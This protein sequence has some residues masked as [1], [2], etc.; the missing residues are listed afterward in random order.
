ML[1]CVIERQ[2]PQNWLYLPGNKP[3]H[4]QSSCWDVGHCCLGWVAQTQNVIWC[5]ICDSPKISAVFCSNSTALIDGKL[6]AKCRCLRGLHRAREICYFLKL[7][8]KCW[9]DI[10]IY[11]SVCL[12][13]SSEKFHLRTQVPKVLTVFTPLH[14]ITNPQCVCTPTNKHT[15]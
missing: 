3:A 11:L 14:L 2:K 8:F 4:A 6:R 9:C 1:F 15:H 5:N 13:F 10:S 7:I 12:G